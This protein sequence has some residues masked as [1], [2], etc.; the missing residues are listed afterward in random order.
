[1]AVWEKMDTING[2]L[3][4]AVLVNPKDCA[5][6]ASHDGDEFILMKVKT[7]VPFSYYAGAGWEKSKYFKS[8]VDW[9][10]YIKSETKK[11]KF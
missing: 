7:N 9:N 8:K 3:G 10:N 6:F 4:T 1:L 2:S 11:V 5:G